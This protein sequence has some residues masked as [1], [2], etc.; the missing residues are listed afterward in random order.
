MSENAHKPVRFA[1]A[2]LF[3]TGR[4][5]SRDSILHV[6]C[7]IYSE[8]MSPQTDDWIVNP[9]ETI[10]KGMWRRLWIRTGIGT[11]EAKEEPLWGEIRD[12]VLSFLESVDMIFVHNSD[13][14]AKW[15]EGVVYKDMSPPV[16]VDLM[17]MYQFFLPAEPV[18]YSDSDLIKIG[19]SARVSERNRRLHRVL[20]GMTGVL[21]SIL[22]VILKRKNNKTE[23]Y[24]LVYSILHWA[25]SVEGNSPD[26]RALFKIAAVA[27]RIQWAT[28]VQMEGIYYD[29]PVKLN[30][31]HL[32]RF[33]INWMPSEL[34]EKDRKPFDESLIG[35]EIL[36]RDPNDTSTSK[37]W[38][39]LR[40]LL[41][42]ADEEGE[43]TERL[44]NGVNTVESLL[45]E[46][47]AHVYK[48]SRQLHA[49]SNVADPKDDTKPT[50]NWEDFSSALI[51]LDT[52]MGEI[53]KVLGEVSNC[54]LFSGWATD[55]F[56]KIRGQVKGSIN[57]TRKL[58]GSLSDAL[59][60]FLISGLCLTDPTFRQAADQVL[61]R[62]PK[63]GNEYFTRTKP[64]RDESLQLA[65][66]VAEDFRLSVTGAR[67]DKREEQRKYSRF[68]QGAM[69][70][71]GSYAIEAGTGT[72]KTLGYLIPGCEHLRMN[73]ERQ[74]V[75]AT[76]TINLM[77]QIVIKEWA[78]LA[79]Q[80]GSRYH[81]LEIAILKGKRNY[82]CVSALKRLFTTLDSL[83]KK[84]YK[85]LEDG[86]LI[87]S[88][89]RIAW[90]NLFQILTHKNGQWDNVGDFTKKFPRISEKFEADL[91]AESVCKPKLCG[92][93]KNCS[94]PQ[95]V[96]RAQFAHVLITNHHK[97]TM[98][99]DEIQKRASVCII[100][101]A[102]QYPDN[103]RSALSERLVKKDVMDFARRVAGT[104]NRRGFVQILR[105]GLNETRTRGTNGAS[106][107]FDGP[108]DI[109]RKIEESCLQVK[110]CLWNSTKVSK[111][112]Y[113]V[114][115]KDLFLDHQNT[116]ND[117]L[118]DLDKHLSIIEL[119]LR[120]VLQYN[121]D[122]FRVKK[123]KF[124]NRVNRYA[125]DAEEFGG[126]ARGL[127]AAI[128]TD[129]FVV[130]YRQKSYDWTITKMPFSIG[131]NVKTAI[132]SFETVVLTSGTLY[133]DRALDLLLLELLDDEA[134]SNPFVADLKILSPF[135][136]DWQVH[137]AATGF[138][139]QYNPKYSNEKW[140]QGILETI[141]L[142]SVAQEGRTLVLFTSWDEMQDMY[143]R[144]HPVMQEFGIPLLLQ[145][146]V[147]SSEAIIREFSGLEESVL[148]GTD[149]F[150]AGVDFPGP[151]LSQLMIV[152]LPNKNLQDPLVKE[153]RERWRQDTFWDFWYAQNT[154]R[155]L[156]QGFGRL[157]RKKGDRGLFIV[158]DSRILH[159]SR[160]TTHQQAIPVEF[161]TEFK[162]AIE[163]ANWSVQ[164]PIIDERTRLV[165]EIEER[166]IDLEQTYQRLELMLQG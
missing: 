157:I 163:L 61:Q 124:I 143:D 137:G 51:K 17:E 80:P 20:A 109:L 43:D 16:L 31:D 113:E 142:Q 129:E 4:D 25:L 3:T 136:Y 126:I 38:Q 59:Q 102:D 57:R 130:T 9:G 30:D 88:D 141:A 134:S 135:H 90:L 101:E 91:D 69:N 151:T 74:V 159:D 15:F 114:R 36:D 103:L 7:R 34:I 62:F 160:M 63:I 138:I 13:V 27:A 131:N 150:W 132:R 37:L 96:R 119:E 78:T 65:Y 54:R 32:R 99:E 47:R 152:R 154:R 153:R 50:A 121:P 128:P 12:K 22:K 118:K 24:H 106:Q 111:S 155:K 26:F 161:N 125:Y 29:S 158:L 156:R 110:E 115:W 89:D 55:T 21:D 8:D 44:A 42:F 56:P 60:P 46:L 52:C 104:K 117:I 83:Y 67:L 148:F 107:Y 23:D 41:A 165:R 123:S 95:A 84:G 6:A 108:L 127:I 33:I 146:R 81:D 98:L 86:E 10:R 162:N 58:R 2:H 97:L 5:P 85:S 87:H 82:L 14:K 1:I 48:V 93:D 77:D 35:A 28:V 39:A 71:G 66:E 100:D 139:E 112:T 140:K 92:M 79:S 149:R 19:E 122:I 166:D 70:T 94:Y 164:I 11:K 49:A 133:V 76:A 144:I 147:G 40:F 75:V 73:K 18:P 145:D 53:E 116:L 45:V 64:I 68:I 105:D 72:G 120:Q